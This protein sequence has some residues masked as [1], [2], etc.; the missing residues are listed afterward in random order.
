MQ[1]ILQARLKTCLC[2]ISVPVSP[3]FSDMHRDGI[4]T[5]REKELFR[6]G[7]SVTRGNGR[8]QSREMSRLTIKKNILT[9]K[10]KK[11]V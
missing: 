9:L 2:V 7:R 4:N 10:P 3:S 1:I 6:V 8:K 5:R 11:A